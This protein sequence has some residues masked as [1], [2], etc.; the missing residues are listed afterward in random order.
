MEVKLRDT[1][2]A[3]L[4]IGIC[5]CV[6][7]SVLYSF[8]S[9]IGEDGA[10]TLLRDNLSAVSNIILP[11]LGAHRYALNIYIYI[12]FK[13]PSFLDRTTFISITARTS[14][15]N[16]FPTTSE[17]LK[18]TTLHFR[19][20]SFSPSIFVLQ[21]FVPLSIHPLFIIFPS[22]TLLPSL[23][24]YLIPP[25]DSPSTRIAAYTSLHHLHTATPAQT[26]LTRLALT[27]RWKDT[28]VKTS[29]WKEGIRMT[30]RT[31]DRKRIVPRTWKWRTLK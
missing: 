12:F 30:F 24:N 9:E 18:F 7:R 21:H 5:L 1:N 13:P 27:P 6:A 14:H 2:L 4:Q 11:A 28:A 17:I 26:H 20:S 3:F 23:P 31:L 25:R 19:S 10:H 8:C 15:Y 22:P 16:R 29:Q